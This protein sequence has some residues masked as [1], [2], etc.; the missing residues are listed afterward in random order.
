[1][2]TKLSVAEGAPD[3]VIAGEGLAGPA[4]LLL[5]AFVLGVHDGDGRKQ[6]RRGHSQS[7]GMHRFTLLY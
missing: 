5:A 3:Q 1:M 7:D 4:A 2:T 6:R